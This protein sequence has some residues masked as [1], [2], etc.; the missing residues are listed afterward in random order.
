MYS[1]NGRGARYWQQWSQGRTRALTWVLEA[2]RGRPRSAPP[3]CPLL[4]LPGPI[5]LSDPRPSGQLSTST[6]LRQPRTSRNPD[7]TSFRSLHARRY[8]RAAS[9]TKK[10][11]KAVLQY[12]LGLCSSNFHP[13]A[14]SSWTTKP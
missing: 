8:Y 13:C 2:R 5:E 9:L 7:E 6:R 4:L 3:L 12:H 10:S 1:Q 11:H 14:A